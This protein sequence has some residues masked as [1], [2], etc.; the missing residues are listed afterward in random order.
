M[1][2]SDHSTLAACTANTLFIVIYTIF[3]KIPAVQRQSLTVKVDDYWRSS[4][5]TGNETFIAFNSQWL[6]N[7]MKGGELM[8]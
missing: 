7:G 4:K 1:E 5:S 3:S 2:N 6:L 8:L